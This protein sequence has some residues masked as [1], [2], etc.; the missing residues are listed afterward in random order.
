MQAY[1][2]FADSA[3]LRAPRLTSR[4]NKGKAVVKL[5]PALPLPIADQQ[6]LTIAQ[7]SAPSN[8]TGADT[9]V[10]VQLQAMSQRP[11][12]TMI[13]ASSLADFA[14]SSSSTLPSQLGFDVF[15]MPKSTSQ[16]Q[17][18]FPPAPP[19]L[20]V[21]SV[22]DDSTFRE[23]PD[24]NASSASPDLPSIL[25]HSESAELPSHADTQ[26]PQTPLASSSQSCQHESESMSDG[27]QDVTAG[28]PH[29]SPATQGTKHA[30]AAS[31]DA[32]IQEDSIRHLPVEKV[33]RVSE[34]HS[35]PTSVL[36]TLPPPPS[37]SDSVANS[38]VNSLSALQVIPSPKPFTVTRRRSLRSTDVTTS[39]SID[40]ALLRPD[41]VAAH[42]I[43][44]T[45]QV[46]ASSSS[47]PPVS[48]T[49]S[50]SNSKTRKTA[51]P[52]KA[53]AK[54]K[55]DTISPQNLYLGKQIEAN[56]DVLYDDCLAGF[57]ALN[58]DAREVR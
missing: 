32:P 36:A 20:S 52:V 22:T 26:H 6:L 19:F 43:S 23:E 45:L 44:T 2:S 41:S 7:N 49:L 3:Q 39:E 24:N 40:P 4:S 53:S 17:S 47:L 11:T 10:P 28:Q 27:V 25:R 55:P 38:H 12:S 1:S 34:S 8:V 35:S 56:P 42:S 33:A 54:Y 46:P 21:H 37:V 16:S 48:S 15:S 58:A 18:L 14:A 30:R 51:A 29:Q 57:K 13:N 31:S 9:T 50:S 5:S